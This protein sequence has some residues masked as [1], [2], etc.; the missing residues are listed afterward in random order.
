M[1]VVRQ[2]F[3]SDFDTVYALAKFL[4]S[5]NLPHDRDPLKEQ[6]ERSVTSFVNPKHPKADSL[7]MFVL[8]DLK[9][10]KIVGTSSVFGKHGTS[11][12]PHTFLKV[13]HKTHEDPN[14][15]IKIDHKLLRFEFDTDG[16]SEIG[17][18]I[19]HPEFRGKDLGLGKFLSYSRFMYMGMH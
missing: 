10:R 8:E 12:D 13:F 1:F 3:N 5:F 6:I 18:L 2:I 9:T 16:P 17:G 14:L 19:L 11:D 4:D 15:K 7:Y